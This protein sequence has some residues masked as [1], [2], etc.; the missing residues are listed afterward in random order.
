MPQGYGRPAVNQVIVLAV[1][2]G[3]AAAGVVAASTPEPV[4]FS[5]GQHDLDA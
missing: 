3:T 4:Q 1:G 5:S 2:A